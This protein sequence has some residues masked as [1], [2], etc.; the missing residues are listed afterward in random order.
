MPTFTIKL[1]T[2]SLAGLQDQLNEYALHVGAA[3]RQAALEVAKAGAEDARETVPV[4]IGGLRSSIRAVPTARGAAVV[5]AS[6]EAAFVEF[7]TGLGNAGPDAARLGVGPRTL[8]HQ[9]WANGWPFCSLMA[10]DWRTTTGQNGRGFMYK[11]SQLMRSQLSET[12]AR[13]VRR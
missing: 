10:G 12:V 4:G 1:S 11:A 13:E 2:D 9:D 7:G 8:G 5:A 3:T 6:R